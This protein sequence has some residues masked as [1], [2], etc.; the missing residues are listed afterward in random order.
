MKSREKVGGRGGVCGGGGIHVVSHVV[1][2]PLLS[3]DR[4]SAWETAPTSVQEA[5]TCAQGW[6]AHM[7]LYHPHRISGGSG[8]TGVKGRFGMHFLGKETHLYF[9]PC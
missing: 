6:R 2:G 8:G 4:Y 9:L 5:A 1:E 3:R 7:L